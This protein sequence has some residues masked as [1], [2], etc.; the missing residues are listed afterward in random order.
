MKNSSLI[1]RTRA[2]LSALLVC[3]SA[4][5]LSG[6]AAAQ[7]PNSNPKPG[8][9]SV[10]KLHG[11]PYLVVSLPVGTPYQLGSCIPGRPVLT[12]TVQ[13][14]NQGT[15]AN[16]AQPPE[17]AV[18]LD[19]S[20]FPVRWQGEISLP[21][22]PVAQSVRINIPVMYASNM[23]ISGAHVF[24]LYVPGDAGKDPATQA[25]NP[26]NVRVVFPDGYCAPPNSRPKP[27]Q[28]AQN[29]SP[30]QTTMQIVPTSGTPQMK[31]SPEELH[32][33]L[34]KSPKLT[35]SPIA[36]I[37]SSRLQLRHQLMMADFQR[38]KSVVKDSRP[39]NFSSPSGMSKSGAVQTSHSGTTEV[40][41]TNPSAHV[42]PNLLTCAKPMIFSVKGLGN[43]TY[44]TPY[45]G[46]N[47][48]AIEGCGFGEGRVGSVHLS[49]PFLG[50][51]HRV[52]LKVEKDQWHDNLIIADL[53]PNLSG[54]PDQ[55][56][57]VT[58]VVEGPGGA[59][60]TEKGGFNFYAVRSD[61]VPVTSIP[62]SQVALQWIDDT[63]GDPVGYLL[64]SPIM[65]DRY[66]TFLGSSAEVIRGS[67][68]RFGSAQDSY[69][70]RHLAAGFYPY[71][72]QLQ[73]IGLD[74]A[75]CQIA[76]PQQ[77][78]LYVDGQWNAWWDD[79]ASALVVSTQE[80]HCHI[81]SSDHDYSASVYAV[82]IWVVGPRG[83]SPWPD[84]L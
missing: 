34:M 30:R 24:R 2:L 46:Y 78:T 54:E 55:S 63:A 66:E 68:G 14:T 71:K 12:F 65:N 51:G 59:P 60:K 42:D 49:G 4:V 6:E 9:G 22:I 19:D 26:A 16:R 57:T 81:S 28:S 53:D 31:L 84:N 32:A 69:S 58:L 35:A 17:T 1:L 79:N 44:F 29:P 36:K 15:L 76:W 83:V 41:A 40:I 73:Q 39:S 10:V 37:T 25:V 61:P 11:Q 38:Q 18:A 80:Q 67:H 8:G 33:K 20:V 52:D 5:L 47:S 75:A 21:E 72:Y 43:G 50:P 70:F 45:A 3:S 27:Q 64:Y 7:V 23:D 77:A 56:G 82:T 74:A 62:K 13:V 48:Y